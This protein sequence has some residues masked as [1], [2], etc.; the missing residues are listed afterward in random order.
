MGFHNVKTLK[1]LLKGTHNTDLINISVEDLMVNSQE[2][3]KTPL[4]KKHE[5]KTGIWTSN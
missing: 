5:I 4:I 2:M 1:L 3:E